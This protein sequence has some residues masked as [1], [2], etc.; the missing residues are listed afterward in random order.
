[1][2]YLRSGATISPL[3]YDGAER[4]PMRIS[5][6]NV[7]HDYAPSDESAAVHVLEDVSLDI[8]SSDFAVLMGASGSGKST[9]LNL[10][11]AVDRPTSGRVFLGDVETSALDETR[12]TELRRTSI[13]FV[14]QFFN[15]IPTL[16]VFENVA[17]PLS[18]ARRPKNEI[19][20]RVAEV[21][22]RVGLAHRASHFPNELSGGEM[23]RVALGRAIVHRPPLI[24]A[25]EPTGN[26]DSKNGAMIL[27]L[28]REIHD[29]LRPT[30][31]MATHSAVAAEY[32]DYTVHVQ[33]GRV[34][35]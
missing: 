30:I 13:G 35:R 32:G 31:V 1:M 5:L 20:D 3:A 19:A 6:R 22:Q 28:I 15:L 7:S 18:L 17:F 34:A 11:G 9:L 14:F 23:Q 2:I 10:I 24:L 27:D 16:N 12:L 26:L 33:D 25:D 21:L 8:A 4:L 29:A